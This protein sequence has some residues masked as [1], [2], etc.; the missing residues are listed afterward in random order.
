[1][2]KD[3]DASITSFL[4]EEKEQNEWLCKKYEIISNGR[5]KISHLL[6]CNK[7]PGLTATG[8]Y[9]H[10]HESVGWRLFLADLGWAPVMTLL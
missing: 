1:M 4:W 9:S 3:R 5:R 2:Y 8:I 10:P 7:T 6:L